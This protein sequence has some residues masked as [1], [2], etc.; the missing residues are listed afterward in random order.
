M[1]SSSQATAKVVERLSFTFTEAQPLKVF[2]DA[3][4]SDATATRF[5]MHYELELGVVLQGGCRRHRE[6]Q[7]AEL[8]P[9]DAWFCGM[10]QTHGFEIV[11]APCR[12]LAVV[13]WP[14]LL[15]DLRVPEMP[16]QNWLR[17]FA[18]EAPL[19]LAPAAAHRAEILRAAVA[20]AGLAA[21]T[22]AAARFRL[23]LLVFELL[24]I[25]GQ[26]ADDAGCAS[27]PGT[28]GVRLRDIN[29][30]LELVFASR[31]MVSNAEAAQRC[32]M[33]TFRF[34]RQFAMLMGISFAQFALRHRLR[35]AAG[36]L[37]DSD[38]P[39][40]AVAQEWG[41]TDESHLHRLFRRHYGC[42]PRGYRSGR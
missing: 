4:D 31:R 8:R 42:T 25:L 11:A 6:Q 13:L 14:P 20:A 9:G 40:K 10:W 3:Y 12:L 35:G 21:A 2:D 16:R 15:A 37:C 18:M 30:A 33:G 19:A 27:A 7:Q 17:L 22:D 32:D 36:L 1:K 23:R 29:P 38:L 39:V 5:D 34:V 41:F 28:D 24:A 26:V